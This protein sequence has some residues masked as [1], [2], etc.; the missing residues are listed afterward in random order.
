[1]DKATNRGGQHFNALIEEAMK[2]HVSLNETWHDGGQGF[3]KD[4]DSFF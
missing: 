2:A 1:M 4:A 3:R